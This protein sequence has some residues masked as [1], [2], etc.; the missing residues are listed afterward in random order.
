MV[1][2]GDFTLTAA[3]ADDAEQL[4]E[5]MR[6]P[7]RKEVELLSRQSAEVALLH[8]FRKA[9]HPVTVRRKDNRM[10]IA[11]YGFNRLSEIG[12]AAAPWLLGTDG[13]YESPKTLV[14]RSRLVVKSVLRHKYTRL[15]NIVWAENE[16]SIRY[17]AAV[18]FK[19]GPVRTSPFGVEYRKFERDRD[20]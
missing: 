12:D 5:E 13:L 9:D 15:V 16:A 19:I 11:M 10:L 4:A 7:D 6:E 14:H 18:G 8:T 17:L 2:V 20:V 3:T 1:E